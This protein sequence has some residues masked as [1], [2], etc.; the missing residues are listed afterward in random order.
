MTFKYELV[1]EGNTPTFDKDLIN[2]YQN[3]VFDGQK[4]KP[5]R[6]GSDLVKIVSVEH[7]PSVSV[8]YY[9]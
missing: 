6:Q 1:K 3:P 8:A 9:Q 2:E 4:V 7:Y 5:R